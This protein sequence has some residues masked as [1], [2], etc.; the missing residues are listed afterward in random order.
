MFSTA[1]KFLHHVLPGVA[2]PVRALWNQFIGFIF[3]VLATLMGFTTWRRT[4]T[5]GLL[6][7]VG[8]YAFTAFL[9]WFAITSFLRA[10]RISR[11]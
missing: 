4:G 8:G 11:S 5:D 10:R 2:R 7:L 3:F 1:G 9:A 6:L